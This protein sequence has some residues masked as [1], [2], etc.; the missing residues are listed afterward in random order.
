MDKRN[1]IRKIRGNGVIWVV[2]GVL[3]V[4]KVLDCGFF[5]CSSLL[6]SVFNGFYLLFL[7]SIEREVGK[8]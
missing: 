6:D 2:F 5:K 4:I 7:Y 3:G 8:N 1:V